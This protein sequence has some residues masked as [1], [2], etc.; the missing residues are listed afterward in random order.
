MANYCYNHAAFTPNGSLENL[1]LFRSA[2]SKYHGKCI[3]ST[4]FFE[5]LGSEA[6]ESFDAY[7]EF[8]SRWF[9]VDVDDMGDLIVLSGSSAWSPMSEFF[10]KLCVKFNLNVESTFEESGCDFGGYYDVSDG[11]VVRDQTY[12]YNQY[13]WLEDMFYES[14]DSDYFTEFESFDEVLEQY[15]DVIGIAEP[16]EE[17]ELVE[18]LKEMYDESR[19][20]ASENS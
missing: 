19:K 11:E 18:F 5:I 13:Q 6:P 2:I 17:K 3:G 16:E 9:E 12:T 20:N 8:G 4:E 15:R 7:D 1:E 10:R 14:I